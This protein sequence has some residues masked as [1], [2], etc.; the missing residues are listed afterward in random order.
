[1]SIHRKFWA[2]AFL[3]LVTGSVDAGSFTG[4]F[5]GD[6]G[7][8]LFHL[9]SDGATPITIRS[10]GYAGGTLNDGTVVAAGGF[11]TLLSLYDVGGNIVPSENGVVNPS[12]SSPDGFLNDDGVGVPTDLGNGFDALFEGLLD[13]GAYWLA[14]TESNNYGPNQLAEPFSWTTLAEF[15]PTGG[16]FGCSQGFF[17]DSQGNNRDGHWALDILGTQS[18]SQ[19]PEPTTLALLGLGMMGLLR[20]KTS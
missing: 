5:S 17:C 3:A 12:S 8:V 10:Y 11:D 9:V 1:M 19:V 16:L 4:N 20:R 13:A 14:L 18:V 15:N 2:L 6:K 7:V